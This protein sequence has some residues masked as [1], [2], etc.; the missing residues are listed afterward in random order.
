MSASLLERLGWCQKSLGQYAS[1]ET[2][3]Q[4]ASSL[5][6]EALGPEHPSTLTSMSNLALLLDSQGKYEEAEA[7][8]RQML[9]QREK[10]LGLEHPDTLTS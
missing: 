7:M 9:A 3:H 2:S 1:A 10:V 8:N 5:R 4:K 6:K